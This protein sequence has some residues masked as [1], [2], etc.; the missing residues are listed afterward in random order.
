MTWNLDGCPSN[1]TSYQ[2]LTLRD[3][4]HI[5]LFTLILLVAC[6]LWSKPVSERD[7]RDPAN[8]NLKGLVYNNRN[9]QLTLINGR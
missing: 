3:G 2:S 4:V 9:L 1:M 6:L 7:G 8:G 5:V